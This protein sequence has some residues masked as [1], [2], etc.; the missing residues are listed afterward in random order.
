[1]S[2]WSSDVTGLEATQANYDTFV[3]M[4]TYEVNKSKVKA[5]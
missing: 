1:M 2:F 4:F 3:D 5:Q